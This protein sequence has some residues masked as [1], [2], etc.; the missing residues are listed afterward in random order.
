[1]EHPDQLPQAARWILD[2]LKGEK[3][4]AFQGEMGAGK[5]TLIQSIC[6]EL[7]VITEVTSPTFALVYEYEGKDDQAIFH[8]DFYRLNDPVEALDFGLEEYFSGGGLCLMEWPEKVA[9]FLPGDTRT[10]G[11]D[12]F[13][14]G[15]R[16][17]RLG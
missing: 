1:M 7:G 3:H 8:F 4:L 2:Q 6:K 13:P 11:I 9:E 16:L 5:T 14:D 12:V 10:I 17:L 15:S